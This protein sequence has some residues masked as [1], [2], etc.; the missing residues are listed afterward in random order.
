MDRIMI[1]KLL[2][3]N[4]G[5]EDVFVFLPEFYTDF[6]ELVCKSGN[7]KKVV[8]KLIEKLYAIL[9]LNNCDCGPTWLEHLKEYGNMYSL[10]IKTHFENYRVLFS[11]HKNGKVFLHMFYE[12]NDKSNTSYSS[13]VPVA[14]KRMENYLK[15]KDNYEDCE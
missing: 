1:K 12:K 11:K 14:E 9:E 4:F 8:K 6:E 2:E 13:H 7:A 10:H 3:I 5:S 15:G